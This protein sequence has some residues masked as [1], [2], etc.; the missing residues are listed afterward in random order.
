MTPEAPAP[1]RIL[2]VDDEALSRA[3]TRR[4]LD[5]L[6]GVTIVGEAASVD[7]AARVAAATA[8]EL[9]LLDIQMPGE[10][11]FA[12]LPRL[13]TRP[14]IVFVTAFDHYAVRAFEAH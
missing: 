14:V 8:P 2:I 13:V 7:E 5:E 9:I 11:G 3:R 1:L 12:L 6:G 4:L 10:D